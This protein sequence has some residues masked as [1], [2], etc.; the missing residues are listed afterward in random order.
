MVFRLLPLCLLCAFAWG[1]TPDEILIVANSSAPEGVAV[2][3]AY[4]AK[5]HVPESQIVTLPLPTSESIRRSDYDKNLV[6]PLRAVLDGNAGLKSRIRCLLTVY[7][8]PVSVGGYIPTPEEL[9]TAAK[10]GARLADLQP[11]VQEQIDLLQEVAWAL[12]EPVPAPLKPSKAVSSPKER[13]VRQIDGARRLLAAL[14]KKLAG[15]RRDA[16]QDGKV[17]QLGEI[18]TR[19]FGQKELREES[20]NTQKEAGGAE[21][22][23]DSEKSKI[24]STERERLY[25]TREKVDG[26]LGLCVQLVNDIDRVQQ[27][28]SEASVDSELSLLYWRGYELGRWMPNLLN[29]AIAARVKSAQQAR[30]LMVSRLDGPSAELAGAL[31][32]RAL[33][34]ESEGLTGTFYIDASASQRAKG[35]LYKVYDESLERLSGMVREHTKIGVVLDTESALFPPEGCP[36]AALYCGWYNPTE[37]IDS[38]TWS[39]GAIGYHIT[40]FG[41]KEL[42]DANSKHWCKRMIEKGVAATLGPVREPYLQAFPPPE[43]FFRALLNGKA[44]LVECY[45]LTNPFTS[46]RMML[47]GDPLYNPFH[48]HPATPEKAPATAVA[49]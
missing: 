38:F 29:P 20:K 13:V 21:A 15:W 6:E 14:D 31:V 1:L 17:E 24:G 26:M 37:Y 11:S 46:W 23:A 45:Y 36:H 47:I 5:R 10:L 49:Q 32:D 40:S 30:T 25:S 4:C 27:R 41:G 7:G 48:A 43:D 28:E 9:A 22:K 8:V 19:L 33:R 39:P 18:R 12:D 2:A 44:T 3:K 34:G 35:G 42:H 16:K